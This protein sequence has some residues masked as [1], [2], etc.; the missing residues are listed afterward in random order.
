MIGRSRRPRRWLGF[1]ETTTGAGR[2]ACW[3]LLVSVTT[4]TARGSDG[5]RPDRDPGITPNQS[6]LL[7]D[8]SGN[9]GPV[10]D[11]ATETAR[12]SDERGSTEQTA[13]MDATSGSGAT[14]TV[15]RRLERPL[16]RAH[17][18]GASSWQMG[19]G[20][21]AL[22]FVLAVVAIAFWA[23]R[24][25]VPSVRRAEGGVMKIAGRISLTPKHHVALVQVAGRFLLVGVSPDGLSTLS[26]ISD[27][28]EVAELVRRIGAGSAPG[29]QAFDEQLLRE[30]GE[31]GA[32][33]AERS[34]EPVRAT[35]GREPLTDLLR[36]LRKLRST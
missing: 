4:S 19:K 33:S 12:R 26:E 9:G 18:D 34:T 28:D 15:P 29:V 14:R 7:G 1:L 24:R 10:L 8:G 31:Y 36:K 25:W 32:P 20:L 17:R 6:V 23:V 11:T 21:G 27:P 30:V 35:A 3:M 13:A 5:A 2:A 16:G 22:A